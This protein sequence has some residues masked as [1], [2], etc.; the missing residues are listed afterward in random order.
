MKKFFKILLFVF[1][2][3][4][5]LGTFV[6]LWQ[7]S[8][9]K[10]I[11]YE[12]V[13]PEIR[14][15]YKKSVINGKIEPRDEILLKPQISGIITE[16][17]KEAGE[18]VHAGDVIA[19]VKVVP[20]LAQLSSAESR[21]NVA[22]INFEQVKSDYDRVLSLYES[23]V[24]SKESFETSKASY[25]K[26]QEEVATAKE[27]IEIIKEGMSKSTAQYSNTQIKSTITGMILDIPVKVG[28][29]VIQTNNFNEGTTIATIANMN[30]LI[31]V[32]KIDETEVGKI[33]EGN[34][35]NLIIGAMHDVQCKAFLE[36][37]APK[38]TLENGATTFEIKA[39]VAPLE[40]GFIR[41]GYSANGEIITDRR[42][43]VLSIPEST[44]E[45]QGDSTFVYVLTDTKDPSKK[46]ERK[47]VKV[48]LSD[49]LYIEVLEGIEKNT[50]LRGKVKI[51]L[52]KNR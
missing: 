31:F 39:A 32:G 29:S 42:D 44:I 13:Q 51:E 27:T 36:Y 26:A 22:E 4:L 11:E 37:I 10:S 21:L 52:K 38:G 8:R 23:G 20:D 24:V 45:F 41:S 19:K 18:M 40:D 2:G 35:V 16:I 48:G 50:T 6:F 47:H 46:Y 28:N 1:F 30:D 34:E 12:E 15:I 43:S 33:A 5:V 9:P 49:G 25:L 17:Y 3:L 7:K 14:S